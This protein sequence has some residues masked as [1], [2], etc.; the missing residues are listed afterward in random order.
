MPWCMQVKGL[1]GKFAEADGSPLT[2]RTDARCS[3]LNIMMMG[4]FYEPLQRCA[5]LFLLPP[6][7][8]CP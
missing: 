4:I 8:S 6:K 7:S 1:S 3:G 2:W 5:A